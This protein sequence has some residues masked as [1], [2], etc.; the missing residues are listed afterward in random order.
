MIHTHVI[1]PH[2]CLEHVSS[3]EVGFVVSYLFIN[4]ASI[5]LYKLNFSF[6]FILEQM[7]TYLLCSTYGLIICTVKSISTEPLWD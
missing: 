3:H 4:V 7:F 2:C 1:V 5:I 6:V